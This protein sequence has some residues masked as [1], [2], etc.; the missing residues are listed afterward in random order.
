VSPLDLAEAAVKQQRRLAEDAVARLDD[1]TVARQA[2]EKAN[3]DADNEA[4]GA[5][6]ASSAA[7]ADDTLAHAASLAAVRREH[8]RTDLARAVGSHEQAKAE[9]SA[10]DTRVAAAAR[11]REHA[12]LHEETSDPT[13]DEELRAHGR[14]IAVAVATIR[15]RILAV[16][17]ILRS[18]ALRVLRARD[19]GGTGL[20]M[21][22]GIA[23]AAGFAAQLA[24]R[25]GALANGH[26]PHDLRFVFQLP[27]ADV[28]PDAIVAARN[29]VAAGTD[30]IEQGLRFAKA[31]ISYGQEALARA[32]EL[33]TSGH[34]HF[35]TVRDELAARRKAEDEARL[36]QHRLDHQRRVEAG[37]ASERNSSLRSLQTTA[38]RN[39]AAREAQVAIDGDREWSLGAGEVESLG[40]PRMH[41]AAA[42]PRNPLLAADEDFKV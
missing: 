10:A 35:G 15:E 12:Q 1:A 13:I 28:D 38:A 14:A 3:A 41:P 40:A 22:D 19:L 7:R 23:A 32:A 26:E 30:R 17:E 42:I 24:D 33:W 18:D 5:M 6:A 27:I 4:A 39:E 29:A 11:A 8:A 16:R 34:R 20:P 21:R 36:D 9:V 2:A 25:G 37:V 31:G